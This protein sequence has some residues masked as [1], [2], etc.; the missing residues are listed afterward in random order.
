MRGSA[1]DQYVSLPSIKIE[2]ILAFC[3]PLEFFTRW[4]ILTIPRYVNIMV[5][6]V[7]WVALSGSSVSLILLNLEKLLFFRYPL[8]YV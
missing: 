3:Y 6:F 5:H 4:D 8:R 2:S 1:P 7:T